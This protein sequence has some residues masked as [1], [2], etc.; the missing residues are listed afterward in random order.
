[1]RSYLALRLDNPILHYE[2]LLRPVRRWRA[3]LQVYPV[4]V[5]LLASSAAALALLVWDAR[6]AGSVGAGFTAFWTGLTS[7]VTA[8]QMARAVS[9]ERQRSTWDALVISR[10]R[11]VDI[12]VGKLARTL[13]PLWGSWLFMAP[14]LIILFTGSGDAD[15]AVLDQVWGLAVRALV[16]STSCACVAFF[17]SLVSSTPA[18]AQIA[19]LGTMTGAYLL[20]TVA[21][22]WWLAITTQTPFAGYVTAA[23]S[24]LAMNARHWR[25]AAVYGINVQSYGFH[26]IPETSPWIWPAVMALPGVVALLCLVFGFTALDRHQRRNQ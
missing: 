23:L 11:P 3:R 7:L 15:A 25:M 4:V 22:F 12:I 24:G 18:G 6:A 26:Y 2:G 10:L 14:A 8:V 5:F 19:T 9:L 16:L 17:W 13:L 21:P 20:A 1:M